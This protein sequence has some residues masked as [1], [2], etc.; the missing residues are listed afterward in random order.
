MVVKAIIDQHPRYPNY[1]QV[2]ALPGL[3]HGIHSSKYQIQL[4]RIGLL[5][6]IVSL[7]ILTSL[8]YQ[9]Y[10]DDINI[11]KYTLTFKREIRNPDGKQ[12]KSVVVVQKLADGEV[13]VQRYT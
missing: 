5:K 2:F 8:A 11:R 9:S 10:A 3:R 7:I 1:I 12:D 6:S 4:V 13:S